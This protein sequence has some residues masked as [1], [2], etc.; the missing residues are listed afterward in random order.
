MI[1]G[2]R[3]A[4]APTVSWMGEPAPSAPDL[5]DRARLCF[6]LSH[7][8]HNYLR[9]GTHSAARARLI[10]AQASI[11]VAGLW[12]GGLVAF[13]DGLGFVVPVRTINAAKRNTRLAAAPGRQASVL[14][15]RGPTRPAS[16]RRRLPR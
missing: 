4:D 14:G 6:G 11:P 2:G 3:L 8:D 10:E 15:T 13:A 12:G 5:R 16:G 1:V 7:V 9:A